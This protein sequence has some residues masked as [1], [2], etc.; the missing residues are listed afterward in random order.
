[1]RYAY[2]PDE[3]HFLILLIAFSFI[4]VLNAWSSGAEVARLE[5]K[6]IEQDA[7]CEEMVDTVNDLHRRNFIED[8]EMISEELWICEETRDYLFEE[9]GEV[10]KSLDSCNDFIYER[11]PEIWEEDVNELLGYSEPPC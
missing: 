9:I 4:F 7:Y 3:N 8:R 10:E 11:H 2:N 6:L 1:V 5:E